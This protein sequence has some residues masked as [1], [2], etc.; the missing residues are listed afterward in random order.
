MTQRRSALWPRVRTRRA[1]GTLVT[2]P[3]VQSVELG[4]RRD[5]T[6]WLP[7]G[8]CIDLVTSVAT[9]ANAIPDLVWAEWPLS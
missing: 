1:R 9:Q 8:N 6:V 7:P 4:N 5:L 3:Q 2:L